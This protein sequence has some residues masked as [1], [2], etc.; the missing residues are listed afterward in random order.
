MKQAQ[1]RDSF[2]TAVAAADIA[3]NY[4]G[5]K[6]RRNMC[7]LLSG[8]WMLAGCIK[9]ARTLYETVLLY[10]RLG[11]WREPNSY[12]PRTGDFV[13]HTGHWLCGSL[14]GN[15]P[16]LSFVYANDGRSLTVVGIDGEDMVN[17]F[18]IKLGDKNIKG[19]C[20]PDYGSN[21]PKN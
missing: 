18:N 16:E 21:E 10:K 8:E 9:S 20:C 12:S 1:Q 17:F 15:E 13:A 2:N 14:E 6:T 11:R 3:L 4:V 19:Y 5:F 7:E